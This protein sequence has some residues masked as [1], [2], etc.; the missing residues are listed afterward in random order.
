MDIII[1]FHQLEHVFDL[2]P[3]VREIDRV[4]RP[5]GWVVGA[6]PCEGGLGWGLGRFLTSRRYV[7]KNMPFNFDKIIC[8]EHPQFVDSIQACLGG[9]FRL[10][11][12]T[13][14]PFGGMPF[15]FNLSWS[16]IYTKND[17]R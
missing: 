15:D 10:R 13:R 2:A 7:K 11:R 14:R 3:F 4:L 8:W 5:G 6:V 1:A 16:F 12:S 9:T 17:S